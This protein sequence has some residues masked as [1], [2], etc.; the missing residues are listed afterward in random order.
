MDKI[1]KKILLCLDEDPRISTSELAKKTR[2][3]QQR[4]DY[5]I[6]KLIKDDVIYSFATSIN[7]FTLG[8]SGYIVLLRFQKITGQKKNELMKELEENTNIFWGGIIGGKYDVMLYIFTKT[9]SEL[10]TKLAEIFKKFPETFCDYE[11]MPITQIRQY[12]YAHL[13][14]NNFKQMIIKQEEIQR[15]ESKDCEILNFIKNDAR[16]PYI[17]IAR[18]TGLNY[19]TIKSKIENMKKKKIIMGS[20]IFVRPKKLNLN[21]YKVLVST[22]NYV[23][24][25][26][27]L[28]FSYAN[29]NKNIIYVQKLIGGIWA[30]SLGVEIENYEK[31]QDLLIKIRNKFAG[32]DDFEIL[33]VFRDIKIDHLP[34]SKDLILSPQ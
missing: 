11:V 4:A 19:K 14:R 9:Y 21:S 8:F 27:D 6:N 25:N 10:N 15:L 32:I 33:P 12:K 23:K 26:E 5:R 29:T 30:Y 3:S 24:E 7:P 1:D 20:K 22:K 31:L 18:H 28:L 16:A 17:E 2:I 34:M 13:G